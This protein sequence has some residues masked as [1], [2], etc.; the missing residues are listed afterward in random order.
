MNLAR[1]G[2]F[3]AR[4][5]P[6]ELAIKYAGVETT[7][8]E[9][10][11]RTSNLAAGLAGKGIGKGDRI[12]LLLTNCMEWIELTMAAWK[13]GALIVPINT[14]FTP[15]EVKFVVA[16]AGAKLLFTNDG[17][18][19]STK[20]VDDC[21]VIRVE[22]IAPLY[23]NGSTIVTA[24]TV[25]E[26]AAF[27][28]YTSGTTGDPKGAVLTHGSFNAGSQSWAQALDLW[29]GDKLQLPFPLAFTGGLALWLYTYWSGGSLLLDNEV[30]IDRIYDNFEKERATGFMGVPT[31]FQMIVDHPRWKTADLSS[32]KKACSGGAVVP[33]S[34][35][36]AVQAR[37]VP[38]LQ[39]FSLT[40]SSAAGTVLPSHD[41]LR[42]V[43]SA[44]IPIN[45]GSLKIA[46]DD[47][48]E[49]PVGEVGEILLKGP[50]IMAG[51]WNNPE[52]TA[53]TLRGGW[54]H[55]GDLGYVDDEGYLFVVDRKK[56]MLISGGLNV[57]P[58]E[59]ERLIANVPGVV[60]VAVVGVPDERWGETPLVI[61][62]TNGAKVEANDV[63]QVCRDNLA[64]FKLP[65]Y[66]HVSETPLP[67]NMSGKILKRE[68]KVQFADFPKTAQ[69]IR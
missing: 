19:E 65:R 40:E 30:N 66:F 53:A 35:L 22:Q 55:T 32:W 62:F 20:T 1:I 10:D 49:V 24:D 26:D 7:W 44:G 41:A 58:A 29:P 38:M 56:D 5:R 31:I 67:R 60:E 18:V 23:G 54:L 15:A 69:P 43:G 4:W 47:D 50:Q 42:K 12:G 39:M 63:L 64:D 37:G 2:E 14:R 45:H 57:Y 68:L 16:N 8:R 13:L 6:D 3:W 17:L 46:D 28:C 9:L 27:I 61:V 25:P 34:L 59:L 52:A 51:Y 33:P 21:E 11:A 48:N 36:K